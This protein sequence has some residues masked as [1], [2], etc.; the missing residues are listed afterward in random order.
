[1]S[2]VV[3]DFGYYLEMLIGISI[4]F[5]L[6]VVSLGLFVLAVRS[7]DEALTQDLLD[8][9]TARDAGEYLNILY[10]RQQ[11]LK[12]KTFAINPIKKIK[13]P[14]QA[15]IEIDQAKKAATDKSGDTFKEWQMQQTLRAN[16]YR[17][18]VLP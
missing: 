2:T 10:Y 17:D 7:K 14:T 12:Q 8:R 4:G 11:H 1:L 15:E 16:T 18:T 6:G 3:L 9:I 13:I 5:F